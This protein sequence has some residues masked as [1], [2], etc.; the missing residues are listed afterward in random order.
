MFGVLLFLGV[1]AENACS[2]SSEQGTEVCLLQLKTGAD[3]AE[4]AQ[5]ASLLV[6]DDNL[7]GHAKK[8]IHN[9]LDDVALEINGDRGKMRQCPGDAF[10]ALSDN[11]ACTHGGADVHVDFDDED[12]EEFF[13]DNVVMKEWRYF[14]NDCDSE[15]ANCELISPDVNHH[16]YPVGKTQ[17]R[18]E[19]YDL[20]GNMNKCLRTVYILDRQAP[21]FKEPEVDLNQKLELHFPEDS[22]SVSG[23]TPFTEYEEQAGFTA[24][25]TDN[26]DT[27]VKV[28]KKL[29]NDKGEVIYDSSTNGTHFPSLTGPGQWKM[30]YIAVDDYAKTLDGVH[31]YGKGGPQDA[32]AVN[33]ASH[34]VDLTISDITPP[35]DYS[36]CPASIYEEIDAHENE[37][38]V[39]WTPPTISGDN[40]EGHGTVPDAMEQSDPQKY[41][42]MTLPVGSHV[43]NYAVEDA[44]GNVLEDAECSFTVEVKQK[45][46][47]VYLTCPDDVIMTTLEDAS[48]AIV[49]WEQPVAT[50][51]GKILD[52]SHIVYPQG[53]EPGLPFP[54]GS[55]TILVHANGEITGKRADEHLMFDEC[56]FN[57]TI[58][59]PQRPEVDGRLYRCREDEVDQTHFAAP[60]R[61]CN[62]SDLAW[63]PH[64]QYIHTHGFDV[65]GVHPTSLAC[66]TSELE[67]EHVCTK[68]QTLEDVEP[69]VSYCTP[70]QGS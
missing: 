34:C 20:A 66:C 23:A 67:V 53:V 63:L 39:T 15:K 70:K 46:H 49:G 21:H 57:V 51:G 42:G 48:F 4:M 68:V 1:T 60:F 27:E 58:Q 65:L 35:Y 64:P 33:R 50:Q 16:Q 54:F 31:A 19:G 40:C 44:F 37:T 17:I 8:H 28:N 22:C 43:V 29:L 32:G 59:D 14:L 10:V 18:V 13:G 69:L 12:I 26:C 11:D 62:G 7:S 52:P 30:C 24:E 2:T 38:I 47:P 45:A 5:E 3:M 56:I 9:P 61:V 36:G 25:A 6:E 55:T 41:P